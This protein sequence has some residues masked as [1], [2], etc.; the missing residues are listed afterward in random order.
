VPQHR[1]EPRGHNRRRC[2]ACDTVQ[3][4]S[5]RG[6]YPTLSPICSG[7]EDRR[8]TRRGPQPPDAGGAP[9][10]EMEKT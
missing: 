3:T 5:R 8:G 1:W 9:K 7:D 4:W 2:Q 10:R 6:W